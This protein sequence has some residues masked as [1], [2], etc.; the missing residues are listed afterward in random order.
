MDNGAAAVEWRVLR[1]VAVGVGCYIACPQRVCLCQRGPL[2]TCTTFTQWQALKGI[3]AR[4]AA[5]RILTWPAC[6]PAFKRTCADVCTRQVLDSIK[7][8]AQL[9]QDTSELVAIVFV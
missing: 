4:L 8:L 1:V 7:S 6:P 3:P 5:E 2:H 9:M